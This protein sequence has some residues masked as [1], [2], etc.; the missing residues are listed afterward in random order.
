MLNAYHQERNKRAVAAVSR[1]PK[2]SH[3]EAMK[4]YDR[5]MGVTS[6]NTGTTPAPR[7]DKR[8]KVS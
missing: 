7:K 4:Q 1:Q 3:A 5:V 6:S 2:T 8:A